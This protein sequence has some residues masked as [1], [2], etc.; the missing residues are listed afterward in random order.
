V[1]DDINAIMEELAATTID[2]ESLIQEH[3]LKVES[4]SS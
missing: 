2:I 3:G 4:L 1:E